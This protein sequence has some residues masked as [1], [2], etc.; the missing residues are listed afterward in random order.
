[1]QGIGGNVVSFE[2]TRNLWPSLSDFKEKPMCATGSCA[3]C[4]Y[5]TVHKSEK[6]IEIGYR[7]SCKTLCKV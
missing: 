2:P 3:G 7:K 1:M 4:I 6:S 5:R